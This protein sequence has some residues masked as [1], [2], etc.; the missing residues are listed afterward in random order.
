ME[1]YKPHQIPKLFPWII[2]LPNER[3]FQLLQNATEVPQNTTFQFITGSADADMLHIVQ[4]AFR[5]G[6]SN[7][8]SGGNT[9]YNS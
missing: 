6:Q 1:T 7:T 9:M 5:L 2:W 8:G 4:T 3:E